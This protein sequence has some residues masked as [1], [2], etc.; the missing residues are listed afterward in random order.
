MRFLVPIFSVALIWPVVVYAE[1]TAEE[2]AA[3]QAQLTELSDRIDAARLDANSFKEGSAPAILANVRAETLALTAAMLEARLVADDSGIKLDYTLPVVQPDPEMAARI[4][5]EMAAQKAII[6]DAEAEADKKQGLIQA[7][8]LSR[9]QVEKLTLARLY[10]TL[11]QARYGAM[12]PAALAESDAPQLSARPEILEQN[13]V[14]VQDT[15]QPPAWADANHNKIDYDH[16][17]FEQL[18]A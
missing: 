13:E 14:A 3:V 11:V 1:I 7:V 12:I 18:D 6:V 16:A 17:V 9:V 15:P 2:R 4:E 10:S 8:A 5:A